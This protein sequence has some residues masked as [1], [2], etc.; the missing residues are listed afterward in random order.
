[1]QETIKQLTDLRNE[2]TALRAKERDLVNELIIR[3]GHDDYIGQ[4]W[5]TL[6]D[7]TKLFIH[8]RNEY[9]IDVPK[10][11]KVRDKHK[12]LPIHLQEVH[13][14]SDYELAELMKTG[15]LEQKSM[16]SSIVRIKALNPYLKVVEQENE[17]CAK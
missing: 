3:M 5:Y 6:E 2:L 4:K 12:Y 16:F 13:E 17:L 10:F 15:T 1:M 7:G 8:T 14:V 9:T 11:K